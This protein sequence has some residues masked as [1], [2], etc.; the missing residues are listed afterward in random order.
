MSTLIIKNNLISGG[1][2]KLQK[3]ALVSSGTLFCL[4]FSNMGCIQNGDLETVSDLA[5]YAKNDLEIPNSIDFA[6]T[7]R[8][9]KPALTSLKG[10]PI[11]NLGSYATTAFDSGINID[12]IDKYLFSKQPK[13]LWVV[14]IV[15]DDSRPEKV[16]DTW[17]KSGD[18]SNQNIRSVGGSGLSASLRLANGEGVTNFNISQITQIGI[19]FQGAGLPNKIF[20]NGKFYVNAATNAVGYSA[21][22]SNPISIGVKA[23][24]KNT[25]IT[26]F[27]TLLEDLTKSGRSASEVIQKDYNYVN[28][29][30]E[31]SG[32]VKRPFANVT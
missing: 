25:T 3:D 5:V 4:D 18:V 17:F 30:N 20:V 11:V 7:D 12:G 21:E 13:S 9:V 19:E 10:F 22:T 28:A 29:L 31:Y 14:W 6:L 8:G 16:S 32:I 1:V 26:L 15:A 24:V 2:G 27:R 23:P